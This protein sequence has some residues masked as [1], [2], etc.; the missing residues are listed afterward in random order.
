MQDA[1]MQDTNMPR[2]GSSSEFSS[3]IMHSYSDSKQKLAAVR[4]YR[5]HYGH[6]SKRNGLFGDSR[7]F[8]DRENTREDIWDGSIQLT[9]FF[10]FFNLYP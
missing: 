3:G 10:S 6:D 7:I 2:I 1:L 9:F 4:D 5:Q 8:Y